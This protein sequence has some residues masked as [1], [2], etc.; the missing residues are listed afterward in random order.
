MMKRILWLPMMLAL[1]SCQPQAATMVHII[2]GQKVLT[3]QPASLMPAAL[4]AEAGLALSPADKV[5]L[6][7]FEL[8]ADYALPPG[9]AYTL[10]IR[11]AVEIT[12]LTPDGES[13]FQSAAA[14]VGQALAQ[15]GIQ[16]YAADFLSLP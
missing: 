3:L 12:L 2:D 16:L 6:N 1:I 9:R 5:Y 7:G 8:P 13:T 4:V 10:Q 14:T 11:R 15:R